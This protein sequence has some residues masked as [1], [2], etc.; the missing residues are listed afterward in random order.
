MFLLSLTNLA[1]L[2]ANARN[3]LLNEDVGGGACTA[4]AR[5]A[6]SS[7]APLA[8][9]L[10]SHVSEAGVRSRLPRH[11]G[12]RGAANEREKAHLRAFG[13]R[14]R[15]RTPSRREKGSRSPSIAPAPAN[16]SPQPHCC[17]PAAW[18]GAPTM[19]PCSS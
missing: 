1:L 3:S 18:G 14:T 19:L 12:L 9:A 6:Q 13:Q 8:S 11:T 7:S 16:D 17:A 4:P 5:S 2:R 15:V 10:R